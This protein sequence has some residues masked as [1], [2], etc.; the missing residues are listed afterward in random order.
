MASLAPRFRAA[1]AGIAAVLSLTSLLPTAAFPCG[2]PRLQHP[3]NTTASKVGETQAAGGGLPHSC[4][5]FVGALI[6]LTVPWERGKPSLSPRHI[7]QGTICNKRE[8]L[9]FQ[10]TSD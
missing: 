1:M 7:Y 6:S 3:D 10:N 9:A 8:T 4:N 5:E 2:A